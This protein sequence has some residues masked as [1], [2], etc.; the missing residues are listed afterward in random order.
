MAPN[1]LF[2][3]CVN[4]SHTTNK[5]QKCWCFIPEICSQSHC[6]LHH[7]WYSSL[8]QSL[9]LAEAT[10]ISSLTAGWGIKASC[11]IYVNQLGADPSPQGKLLKTNTP[12][13]TM[14]AISW[15][16]LNLN[17]LA[18]GCL[19]YWPLGPLIYSPLVKILHFSYFY[20]STVSSVTAKE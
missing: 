6:S 3:H 7:W 5:M 18:K 14:T 15:E 2:I 4:V 20:L 9:T 17:H 10:A 8:L 13:D 19:N 16:I 1:D 11:K 12:A